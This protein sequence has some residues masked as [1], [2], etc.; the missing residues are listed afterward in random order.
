MRSGG[1]KGSAF[2]PICEIAYATLGA[3]LFLLASCAS[4]RPLV[5]ETPE[6][7][8]TKTPPASSNAP[9][10]VS[11]Y[12]KVIHLT[13]SSWTEREVLRQLA[14]ADVIF[15][16]C[17]IR[18]EH[19]G[20]HSIGYTPVAFDTSD[21]RTLSEW[22]QKNGLR[23]PRELTV[24]FAGGVKGWLLQN[25]GTTPGRTSNGGFSTPPA[26]LREQKEDFANIMMNYAFV[27]EAASTPNYK[28]TRAAGYTPVAHELGHV[29]L[30]SIV[31]ESFANVMGSSN[32]LVNTSFTREQC[33]A[34]RERIK[35]DFS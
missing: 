28:S 7:E 3:I 19:D 34:I 2:G 26:G 17:G 30:D 10:T 25:A 24:V 15:R 22:L 9:Q 29:L 13:R 14:Q 20:I 31:H 4:P 8:A 23:Q 1:S 21:V 11:V 16:Q 32:S 6:V 18:L 12:L 27:T 5:V 35:R 33:Q